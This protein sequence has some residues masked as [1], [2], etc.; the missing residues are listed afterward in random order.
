MTR[1][2]SAAKAALP[3]ADKTDETDKTI[4]GCEM[5]QRETTLG[6]VSSV[7]S[8]LSEGVVAPYL[9]SAPAASRQIADASPHGICALTGEPRTWTGRIVSLDAWRKLS[10]WDRHGPAGR[11]H[12][13]ICKAWVKPGDGCSRPG[14]W[15]GGGTG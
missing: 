15:K 1:W 7:M 5:R 8:V 4:P 9:P 10:D 12:C 14:C 2:L 11:L 6:R 3:P 13:G